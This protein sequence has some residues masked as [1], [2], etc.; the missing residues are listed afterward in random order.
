MSHRR[1]AKQRKAAA[2]RVEQAKK[3]KR[4]RLK[5]KEDFFYLPAYGLKAV[6]GE[7]AVWTQ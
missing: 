7:V 1:K 2:M 3:G 4:P 5:A 6:L